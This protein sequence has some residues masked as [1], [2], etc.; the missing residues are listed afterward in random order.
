M[1]VVVAAGACVL[2]CGT[3]CLQLLFGGS[4]LEGSQGCLASCSIGFRLLLVVLW[5][6]VLDAWCCVASFVILCR[7]VFLVC[8]SLVFL[9]LFLSF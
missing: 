3:V 8:W 2:G 5:C 9:Q 7:V 1:L 4:I 6:S